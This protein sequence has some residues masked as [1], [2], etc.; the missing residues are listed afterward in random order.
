MR[1]VIVT[2]LAC[3]VSLAALPVRA[4]DEPDEL[5]PGRIVIIKTAKLASSWRSP[6]PA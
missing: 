4:A 5:M 1:S 3:L 2:A 6:R